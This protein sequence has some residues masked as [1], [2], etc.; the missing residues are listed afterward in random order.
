MVC[1]DI[2]PY[3]ITPEEQRT[4]EE[5]LTYGVYTEYDRSEDDDFNQY[6]EY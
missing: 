2:T 4:E 5:Y 6:P 3:G 1:E